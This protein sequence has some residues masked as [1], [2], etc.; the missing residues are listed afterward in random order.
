MTYS[1]KARHWENQ[2]LNKFLESLDE[3]EEQDYQ[4]DD[5]SLP[6]SPEGGR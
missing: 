3:P 1:E 4:D 5:F 6:L 2:E